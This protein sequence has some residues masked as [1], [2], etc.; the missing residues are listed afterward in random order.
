MVQGELFDQRRVQATPR[1]LSLSARAG[2]DVARA[3]SALYVVTHHVVG[4]V[5]APRF[6]DVL[7]SFGQE[8]V[9]VFFLL[10]GFV[11]FANE[12]NRVARPRGYYLRRLRRIYPPIVLAMLVST[13]SWLL[14]FISTK[15][16]WNSA[17]ATLLSVQDIGFLKPGVISDPYL[18]NDPL[19]SLSYEVFFYATFPLV[20]L[21]WR[22]SKTVTRHTVGF[23]SCLAYVSYMIVPNHFSL[24]MSYFLIW[25][26]GA[27]LARVYLDGALRIRAALPEIA[28]LAALVAA[29]ALGVL[30]HGFEGIGFYPFLM[31]RHFAFALFLVLL[32]LS[33]VRIL[34]ARVSLRLARPAALVASISFGIYVLHYPLLVQSHASSSLWIIPAAAITVGLAYVADRVLP[35]L[36]PSAPRD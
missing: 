31:L 29:A 2:L 9:L 36:L 24:V 20:M 6:I 3:V 33:P 4:S 19:W 8:A 21:L 28:W 26:A 32:V 11:I 34:L 13:A 15:L 1:K 22:R 14:G 17:V 16:S 7:F 23:V 18:G 27:M 30:V 35:K 25:W 5:A 12:R 10:S